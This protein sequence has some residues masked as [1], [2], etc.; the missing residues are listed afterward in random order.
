[1]NK[2]SEPC[3]KSSR[4][5]CPKAILALMLL[6][7]TGSTSRAQY[8]FAEYHHAPLLLN[9]A[10]TGRF[11]GDYRIGGS[12]RNESTALSTNV[13]GHF[14]AD[15]CP[16]IAS[17]PEHDRLAIGLSGYFDKD[18]FNGIKNNGVSLS[19]AY[20]KAL[21]RAG[22][23]HLIAGFQAGINRRKL[24]PPNLIFE[25]QIFNWLNY[26]FF[27]FSDPLLVQPFDVSYADLN[28][29]LAYQRWLQGKHLFN[30]GIS[31]LHINQPGQTFGNGQ[32]GLSTDWGLQTG[33]E[34]VLN[35]RAKLIAHGNLNTTFK[36]KRLNNL[37]LGCLYQTRINESR[38]FLS[39]GTVFRKTSLQGSALA[40]ALGL[41][42]NRMDLQLLYSMP[43]AKRST[44][45]RGAMELGLVFSGKKTGRK[46]KK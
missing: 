6:L 21:D 5:F 26:G 46:P 28:V 18:N 10:N 22:Q 32:F 12:F 37:A 9:P 23:S 15:Y 20:H 29:G 35:E 24:N 41:K 30:I 34:A 31:I 16:R 11:A 44:A 40:P 4:H 3:T 45:A 25:S 2:T 27:G 7:S 36:A 8:F 42:F 17:L 43:L 39:A 1:M 13:K 19:M 38:Y 33:I 14:F